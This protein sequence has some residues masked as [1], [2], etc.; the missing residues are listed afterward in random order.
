[1]CGRYILG[2]SDI[3]VIEQRFMVGVKGRCEHTKRFNVAP[4]EIM[5][6]VVPGELHFLR[7]G[8]A[9]VWADRSVINARIET[10]G[11]RPY[12]KD[13]SHCLV[14][15]TGFYEWKHNGGTTVPYCFQ[16]PDGALFAF[17]GVCD[18]RGYAIVT[19]PSAGEVRD[20]HPRMPMI[21]GRDQERVWLDGWIDPVTQPLVGHVVSRAVN[22]PK[23]DSPELLRNAE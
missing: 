23:N 13:A 21:L 11:T 16:L 9:P 14:P 22:D 20:V 6:V 7:W 2:E 19:M 18:E 8:F 15:A 12:F 10:L 1:M 17:A 3:D 5:P 4:S